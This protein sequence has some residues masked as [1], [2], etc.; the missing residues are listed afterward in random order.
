MQATED[1]GGPCREGEME[2]KAPPLVP[3]A[4]YCEPGETQKLLDAGREQNVSQPA[5]GS[6]GGSAS[7]VGRTQSQGKRPSP[8][9]ESA[10]PGRETRT[11]RLWLPLWLSV[12]DPIATGSAPPSPAISGVAGIAATAADKAAVSGMSRR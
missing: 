5:S 12:R 10:C 7:A 1:D 9:P 8:G 2:G 11:G 6:E 3:P 4:A